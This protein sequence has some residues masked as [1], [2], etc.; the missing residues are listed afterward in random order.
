MGNLIDK[1]KK[2][3]KRGGG[4]GQLLEALRKAQAERD[5]ARAAKVPAPA[6]DPPEESA[7]GM[8]QDDG[9]VP[10]GPGGDD[11]DGSPDK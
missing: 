2:R 9:F 11:G 1:L 4:R 6:E 5:A 8:P 7:E 10:L 3:A